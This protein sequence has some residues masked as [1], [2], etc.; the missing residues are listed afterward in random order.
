[1]IGENGEKGESLSISPTMA[2]SGRSRLSMNSQ[3]SYTSDT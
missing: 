2:A 3:P 1:M